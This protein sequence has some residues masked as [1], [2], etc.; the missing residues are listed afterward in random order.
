MEEYF[1]SKF[2][3]FSILKKS[4]TVCVSE[5]LLKSKEASFWISRGAKI[6]KVD[7]DLPKVIKK[8]SVFQLYPHI[9]NYHLVCGFIKELNI[10]VEDSALVA[11]DFVL[12]AHRLRKIFDHE[13][14]KIWEDSKATN[15]DSVLGALKSIEGPVIWI[16]GGM[17]KNQILLISQHSFSFS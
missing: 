1:E 9:Y 14:L 11:N 4:A 8:T 10:N 5:Q 13:R 12:D 7:K 2:K 17:S 3:L 15:L 16:G 6:V